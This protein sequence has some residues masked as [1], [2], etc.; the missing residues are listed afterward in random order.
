M[1]P[2]PHGGLCYSVIDSSAP[3]TGFLG[4]AALFAAENLSGRNLS[5]WGNLSSNLSGN[6]SGNGITNGHDNVNGSNINRDDNSILSVTLSGSFS[7]NLS[8]GESNGIG[9]D[10][11]DGRCSPAQWLTAAG[12][13][14]TLDGTA[15]RK[16]NGNGPRSEIILPTTCRSFSST[17]D[18]TTAA[19]PAATW[20]FGGESWDGW[21]CE[22]DIVILG[23]EERCNEDDVRGGGNSEF[24]ARLLDLAKVEGRSS[25]LFK[26]AYFNS[27]G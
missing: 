7:G 24:A 3:P 15:G 5:G 13:I 11:N 23:A 1:R 8:S 16:G 10:E 14:D 9:N 12:L 21:G 20:V 18:D 27:T 4:R 17:S 22:V 6:L 25:L 2:S 26:R 19:A